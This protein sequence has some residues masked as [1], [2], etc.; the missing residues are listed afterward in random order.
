MQEISQETRSLTQSIPPLSPQSEAKKKPTAT[1]IQ[2]WQITYLANVLEI[3]AEEIDIAVPFDRYGL[4]SS[5]AVGMSG[6]L[7][8][9]LGYEFDPTL[10]YD[11]PT[12]EA[13]A[14]HIAEELQ[15]E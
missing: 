8:D 2:T 13:L 4:D 7:E 1:E 9:W 12:I 3:D 5:V 15:S 6:D 10:L 11:Y 14:R